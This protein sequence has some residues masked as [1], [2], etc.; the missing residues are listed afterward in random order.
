MT[1]RRRGAA[2]WPGLTLACLLAVLAFVLSFDALRIVALA[3][4]VQPALAWM[5]PLIVDGSTLAFTWA[6]WAFRTRGMGTWYPW[7]MLVLFSV[8]SLIGNALHAH[9]VQVNGMLLPDWV[10]PLVMTMPPIALLATT[11]MI[12]M[13]AGRTF[14]AQPDE[15]DREPMPDAGGRSAIAPE[16]EPPAAESEPEP[17]APVPESSE[18]GPTG[19]TV[20]AT[21]EPEPP[22]PGPEP[23]TPVPPPPARPVASDREL[24]ARWAE[25]MNVG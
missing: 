15:P 5:F 6:T 10:P 8:V 12:V 4:G 9:P 22:E 2:L 7:L 23:A 16:P 19:E 21:P 1:A 13:A 25:Q 3:C 18:P 11:H 20:P 14:D 24:A 17:S